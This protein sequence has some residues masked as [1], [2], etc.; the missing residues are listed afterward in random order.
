MQTEH[1]LF[2]VLGV[3]P[4]SWVKDYAMWMNFLKPHHSSRYLAT[5]RSNVVIF[6]QFLLH[7][8]VGFF[9]FVFV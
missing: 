4:E 5:D 1:N 8:G 9:Y 7:V 6:M 2:H 3:T